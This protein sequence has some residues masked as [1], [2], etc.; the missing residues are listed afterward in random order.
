MRTRTLPRSPEELLDELFT[1]FPQYRAGYAGPIHDDTPTYHS[2]LIAFTT[3]F[4]GELRS[5][6]EAQLSWL[7]AL[8]NAAVAE[9][10]SLENAFDTCLLEHLHQIR[11]LRFRRYLKGPHIIPLPSSISEIATK[12]APPTPTP[13]FRLPR[14]ARCLDARGTGSTRWRLSRVRRRF[15]RR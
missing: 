15:P 2:V 3:F 10:G 14:S 6:S 1:I 7:A 13:V 11:A 12:T 9:P 8:V 5:F 4:G